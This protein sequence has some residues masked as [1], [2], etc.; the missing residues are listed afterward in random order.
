MLAVTLPVSLCNRIL[1]ALPYDE[2]QRILPKLKN[3]VMPHGEILYG[4][5]EP[6]NYVYFPKNSIVSTINYF[7]DGSSLETGITG[8]E[9]MTGFSVALLNDFAQRETSVQAGGKGW[10]MSAEDFRTAFETN[11]V[12]QHLVLRYVFVYFEQ[13]ARA[14]ACVNSHPIS[15]RL[16]R[17]LLM[18]HDRTQGDDLRITQEFMAQMLG[19][20]RPSVTVAA[21]QLKELGAIRY[22]RGNVT[23]RNR[24]ALE[25]ASCECYPLIKKI[26]DR[27]LSIVELRRINRRLDQLNLK[28]E[29]EIQR[30][31]Q[32]QNETNLRVNN[33]KKVF[34]KPINP[35][36]KIRV[37]QKCL[38][39]CNYLN[40]PSAEKNVLGRVLTAEFMPVI[41]AECR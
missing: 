28:M 35:P 11:P 30:R 32:I 18:C 17:W 40:E 31:K 39:I 37:C 24:H 1:D 20:N 14:G 25:Q 10:Q 34:N 3:V 13:V 29:R 26:Y 41:C 22:S 38:R 7:E 36:V 21:I 12:F 33:L 9:G 15:Q 6:I 2:S 27:Y 16:A 8:S 19:V 23:I 5:G 4:I